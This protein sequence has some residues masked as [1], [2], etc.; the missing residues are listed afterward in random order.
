MLVHHRFAVVACVTG[1]AALAAAGLHSMAQTPGASASLSWAALPAAPGASSNP[2]VAAGSEPIPQAPAP[3]SPGTDPLGG[4]RLPLSAMFTQL[5]QETRNAAV[6]QYS[7]LQAIGNAIRDQ[8][9]RFLR[10]I[11]GGR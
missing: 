10:W 6:G 4:L 7:I 3:A 2:T 11:S 1:V 9:E 8:I 5:N